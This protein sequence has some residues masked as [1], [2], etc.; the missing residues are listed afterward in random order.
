[1]QEQQEVKGQH[2]AEAGADDV[3]TSVN[4]DD[5]HGDSV[6]IDDFAFTVLLT[7]VPHACIPAGKLFEDGGVM[8]RLVKTH[9]KV[10]RSIIRCGYKQ[11][12]SLTIIEDE[13]TEE[14]W[15]ADMKRVVT[16]CLAQQCCVCVCVCG[17]CLSQQCCLCVCQQSHTHFRVGNWDDWACTPT[18]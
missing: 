12:D 5:S 1:M 6:V 3:D 9:G 7:G 17:T 18:I 2:E 13:W 16:L 11:I 4:G 8:Q 15:T 14:A 10:Q